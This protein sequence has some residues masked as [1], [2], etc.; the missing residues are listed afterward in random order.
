M[1]DA[2]AGPMRGCRWADQPDCGPYLMSEPD[3]YLVSVRAD[4]GPAGREANLCRDCREAG[5]AVCGRNCGSS[6]RWGVGGWKKR[7]KTNWSKEELQFVL[8]KPASDEL[9][10]ERGP[11]G[12]ESGGERS[13]LWHGKGA[14]QTVEQIRKRA[15]QTVRT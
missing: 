8:R 10:D 12:T 7:Q 9:G 6:I 11:A 3:D 1:C 2:R 13:V 15:G 14:T 4:S 5:W